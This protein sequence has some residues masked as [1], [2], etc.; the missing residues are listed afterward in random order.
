M[1]GKSTVTYRMFTKNLE[2]SNIFGKK[3]IASGVT[4]SEPPKSP[5]N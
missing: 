4:L 3:F 2:L 5:K 1:G